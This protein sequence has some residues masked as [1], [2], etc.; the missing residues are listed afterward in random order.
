MRR[1][2]VAIIDSGLN[3]DAEVVAEVQTRFDYE[4]GQLLER[5]PL[6]DV[7]GHG[8]RVA[9]VIAAGQAGRATLL[10][11]QALDATGTGRPSVIAAAIHWALIQGADLIHMSLGLL[12]NRAVLA[13]AVEAALRAGTLV[14]A[15]A[16]ARG[17]KPFP[18]RYPGVIAAT[19]DVR[20]APG[21]I[22]ALG[23]RGYADFGASVRSE[24]RSNVAGGASIGAAQV[25]RFIVAHIA[26]PATHTEV[27]E[28]LYRSA[29]YHQRERRIS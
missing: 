5:E 21:E 25:S 9:R 1:W 18:A 26:A 13:L 7:S 6:E 12:E 16:P 8:T 23:G 10:V 20:C 28:S 4:S 2:R 3:A 24:W 22:S 29:T 14:V 11:A 15:A 19:G 27:R 17:N